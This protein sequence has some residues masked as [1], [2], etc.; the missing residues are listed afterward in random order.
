MK[1]LVG[2]SVFEDFDIALFHASMDI[3]PHMMSKDLQD[4]VH[5]SRGNQFTTCVTFEDNRGELHITYIH[6]TEPEK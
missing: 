4:Q 3:C 2:V 1:Y 6:Q 5:A